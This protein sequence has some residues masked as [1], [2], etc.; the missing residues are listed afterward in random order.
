MNEKQLSRA[1]EDLK[2]E[3]IKNGYGFFG[4]FKKETPKDFTLK[5]KELDCIGMI[6]SL[7]C[8]NYCGYTDAEKVLQ[9]EENSHYNYLSD[10][11]KLLG[12]EK[13]KR[14]IQ[15]QIDSIKTIEYNVFTDDEGCSYN[16]IVWNE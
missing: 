16:S 4:G 6:N 1:R 8:Y 7:L 5:E 15:G 14:L 12:R 9:C 10:F 3:A 11:I 2:N 13:V